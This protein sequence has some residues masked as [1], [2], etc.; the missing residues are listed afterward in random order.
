MEETL[1]KTETKPAVQQ[2]DKYAGQDR[3]LVPVSRWLG[4]NHL[5]DVTPQDEGKI[6]SILKWARQQGDDRVDILYL[7]SQTE[8]QLDPPPIGVSRLERLYQ[9]ASLEIQEAQIRKE[10]STLQ[11]NG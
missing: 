11:K 8:R 7:L 5:S 1:T 2:D 10:K 6:E 9:W 4:I 3:D